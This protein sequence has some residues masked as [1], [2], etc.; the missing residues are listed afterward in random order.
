MTEDERVGIIL[1]NTG[2]TDAPKPAETRVYLREF[3]SDP[4]VLDI[5]GWKRWLVLNL[6]ILPFRPKRSAEAFARVWTEDGSPLLHLTTMQLEGLRERLPHAEIEIG[7]RYG[8]PSIPSAMRKLIDKQVTRI[9]AAPLFPQYSSAANGSALQRVFELANEEWN[10]PNVSA[11]PPFY[12]D[13][14]FLDAWA[15]VARPRLDEFQPDH[16]LFS[17]HGLPERHVIKSDVSGD[18]C[19]KKPDCC[20]SICHANRH[21]Y[22]AQCTATTQMLAERLGLDKSAYSQSYQSR[23]GRDPWL[24]PP[25]DEVLP[26]LAKDGV[27]RLAVLCPAFV[28]DCLETLEEIGLEGRDEFLEAGGEAYALI[29]CLNDHPAW[30]DALAKLLK[31]I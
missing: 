18:H 20:E 17:Y 30:L 29:P 21:C 16:V 1:I 31:R 28:T 6:F 2:T 27:K 24:K 22:G 19:L 23:L 15:Q 26:K 12:D 25:T 10:V 9:I 3:L 13:A 14:A 7:M 5:P 4:R 8:N 11:L